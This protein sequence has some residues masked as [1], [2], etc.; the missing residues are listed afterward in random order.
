MS[1]HLLRSG[2]GLLVGLAAGL[3]LPGQRPMSLFL[4]G[5]ISLAG[6]ISGSLAAERWLP[7]SASRTAGFLVAALGALSMLLVYVLLVL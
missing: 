1:S 2:F 5:T 7:P 6:A 3:W 4:T